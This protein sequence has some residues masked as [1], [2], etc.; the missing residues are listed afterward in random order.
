ML[1][2]PRGTRYASTRFEASW[3]G[4]IDPSSRVQSAA[5]I[6]QYSI[7]SST[8]PY[9]SLCSGLPWSSVS[10]RASSSRRSAISSAT[11][12]IAAARSNADRVAQSREAAFAAA[13]ARRTS[14]RVPSGTVPSDSPVDGLDAS[15]RAPDSDSLQAPPTT[16]R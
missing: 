3:D 2:I 6:R 15:I 9:A 11:R 7:S 1:S 5:A 4:G 13:I 12:S 10:T 8:S 14:S 16:N